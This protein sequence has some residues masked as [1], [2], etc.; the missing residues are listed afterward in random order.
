MIRFCWKLKDNMTDFKP[1]YHLR[2]IIT[3]GIYGEVSKIKEELEELEEAFEQDNKILA[4]CEL[5]DIHLALEG[6]A[7]SLGVSI[8]DIAKMAAATKRSF[9]NGTRRA[10]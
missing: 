8:E 5:S 9:E 10:K 2:P 3:R 7:N 4:L 6:V 1:G